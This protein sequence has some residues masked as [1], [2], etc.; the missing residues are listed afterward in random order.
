M[1][2][3]A[4]QASALANNADLN[5]ESWI[6]RIDAQISIYAN[7][8]LHSFSSSVYKLIYNSSITK[9]QQ[10]YNDFI[11]RNNL[12]DVFKL[13]RSHYDNSLLNRAIAETLKQYYEHLNYLVQIKPSL[14][15]G[16]YHIAIEW[17]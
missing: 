15:D 14:T 9:S 7:L 5:V 16:D 1:S 17:Q 6:H 13:N 2:L 11:K 12:T 10:I 4:K 8:G 3:E